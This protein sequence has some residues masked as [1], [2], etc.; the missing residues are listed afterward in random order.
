ML[1]LDVQEVSE[2]VHPEAMSGRVLRPNAG[3]PHSQ[4]LQ[5]VSAHHLVPR[6]AAKP[7]DQLAEHGIPEVRV[8]KPRAWSELQPGLAR[9]ELGPGPA[10]DPLP[11]RSIGLGLQ[12]GGVREKLG[13]GDVAERGVVDVPPEGVVQ[14]EQTLVAHPQH[15]H[16]HE[17]LGDRPDAVLRLD[18]RRRTPGAPIERAHCVGPDQV[19]AAHESGDDGG[20]PTLR[21]LD[22]QAVR[23]IPGGGG[24]DAGQGQP[25]F[26]ADFAADFFVAA[27]F[28]AVLLVA[29]FFLTVFLAA[30]L[31]VTGPRAR[32]SAKSSAP[33]SGVIVSGWSSLRKVALVSPSVT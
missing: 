13:N 26:V 1:G 21:L 5:Q 3:T 7:P 2:R 10:T 24:V 9:H 19:T 17:G 22:C 31:R 11:P 29:V 20:Q 16:R 30:R 28:V 14:V 23:E 18:G 12:S 33:R 15:L 32:F 8:V 27:F 4:R 6:E 25:F